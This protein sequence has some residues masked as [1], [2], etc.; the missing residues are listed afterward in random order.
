MRS[1]ATT[2]VLGVALAAVVTTGCEADRSMSSASASP[3]VSVCDAD[4]QYPAVPPPGPPAPQP[5]PPVVTVVAPPADGDLFIGKW[6][7]PGDD[8]PVEFKSDGTVDDSSD[9]WRWVSADSV[10]RLAGQREPVPP[11][12][13]F[14]SEHF[15][16][17]TFY[18]VCFPST[19]T[20]QLAVLSGYGRPVVYSRT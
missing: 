18:E 3:I 17:E 11:V 6:M 4:R 14:T 19:D 16:T 10:P 2:A 1:T 12:V 20:L 9:R 7:A 5:A 15:P 13:E 8:R